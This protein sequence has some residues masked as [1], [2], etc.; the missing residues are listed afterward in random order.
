MF[1]TVNGL[2]AHPLF[3][4]VVVVMLPLSAFGMIALV[5]SHNFVAQF[6]SILLPQV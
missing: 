5:V 1:D 3:I 6:K 2:P 4:H